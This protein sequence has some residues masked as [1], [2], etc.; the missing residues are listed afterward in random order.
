MHTPPDT[1]P[2]E[3][4][5]TAP[6]DRWLRDFVHQL[7]ADRLAAAAHVDVMNTTYRWT[8]QVE[9]GREA[10]AVLHTTTARITEIC[11]RSEREHP[12]VVPC[13]VASPILGGLPSYLSWISD[14]VSDP[15][16]PEAQ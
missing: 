14:S 11:S 10:K 15:A 5:I 16:Q 4:T 8:D 2:C 6:D 13:V 3:V 12:Y 9:S 1:G 7:V